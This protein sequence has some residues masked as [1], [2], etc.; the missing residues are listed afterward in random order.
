MVAKTLKSSISQTVNSLKSD[1]CIHL[2]KS[3]QRMQ[4][5]GT[6]VLFDLKPLVCFV[7]CR[8]YCITYTQ[9]MM[10]TYYHITSMSLFHSE[11][12]NRTQCECY[13]HEEF[14][15]Y[16][17]PVL[18]FLVKATALGALCNLGNSHTYSNNPANEQ[19]VQY[20]PCQWVIVG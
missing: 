13:N 18:Y 20:K 16:F 1:Q 9:Q 8:L 3:K 12:K 4:L 19:I 2:D 15:L 6:S 7:E 17:F 14:T 10:S 5:S 11:I